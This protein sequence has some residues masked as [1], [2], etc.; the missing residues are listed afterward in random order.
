MYDENIEKLESNHMKHKRWG[1]VTDLMSQQF[2]DLS[3]R[4]RQQIHN[5]SFTWLSIHETSRLFLP[6]LE[7]A[8]TLGCLDRLAKLRPGL[9]PTPPCR[10]MGV[11]RV[12][13][14]LCFLRIQPF[15]SFLLVGGRWVEVLLTVG[16]D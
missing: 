6:H 15:Q 2:G 13:V 5:P 14:A 3:P 12:C 11:I 10:N 7:N 16:C 8:N 4:A 9:D 1:R